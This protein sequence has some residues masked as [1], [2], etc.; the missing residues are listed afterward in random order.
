MLDT[1][2]NLHM[3]TCIQIILCTHR[4]FDKSWM[5]GKGI[6]IN[7]L[8]QQYIYAIYFVTTTLSTCGFGDICAT[9]GDATEAFVILMF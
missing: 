2:I 5:G 8:T 3:M 9:D 4:D 7:D 1:F 6:D